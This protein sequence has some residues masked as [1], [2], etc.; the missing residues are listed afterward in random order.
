MRSM[1]W[2]SAARTALAALIV[3]GVAMPARGD[4]NPNGMA[5]RAVGWF[6]GKAEISAGDIQW[7]I[8]SVS[9]AISEGAFSMGIW[10]P[11]GFS[12]LLFP[13]TPNP[14]GNPCGGWIQLQNNMVN[15]GILVDHVELTFRT[16]GARR[17]RPSV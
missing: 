11:Y 2:R 16:P 6:K 10:N 12:S 3:V 13:D 4:N 9:S 5:F 1:W 7:E 14:F 15:Q 17:F 8:P